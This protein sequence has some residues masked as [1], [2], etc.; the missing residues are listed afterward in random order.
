[1]K[2]VEGYR[3]T[4]PH[5]CAGFEVVD[6]LVVRTAPILKYMQG[7]TL[8]WVMR[9]CLTKQWYLERTSA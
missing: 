6:G 8:Y 9:Y 5:F 2:L 1:M 7:Y 3:I 4:A